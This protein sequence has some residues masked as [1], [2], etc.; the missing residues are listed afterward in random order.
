MPPLELEANLGNQRQKLT[1]ECGGETAEALGLV[2]QAALGRAKS[3]ISLQHSRFA[4][5]RPAPPQVCAAPLRHVDSVG[6]RSHRLFDLIRMVMPKDSGA[7]GLCLSSTFCYQYTAGYLRPNDD[8]AGHS[9]QLTYPVRNE[10]LALL[11]L[12]RGS[13]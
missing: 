10:T 8:T 4:G 6:G 11:A 12:L 13:G 7:L 3:R 2:G 5:E 1:P 9:P